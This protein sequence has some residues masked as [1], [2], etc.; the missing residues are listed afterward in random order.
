MQ[1]ALE[2]AHTV[3]MAV[4]NRTTDNPCVHSM[5]P[6]SF[7]YCVFAEVARRCDNNL[8]LEGIAGFS[9]WALPG[10]DYFKRADVVHLHVIHDHS[11]F[12]ILSLPNLS[13]LKPIVWTIHDPWAMTGGCLYS[14]ECDKWLD[15]CNFPC[16]YP[17]HKSLLQ[18][19]IPAILWQLK[20]RVYQRSDLSLVVASKWMQ[21]RVESSPL[22]Q[23]FPCHFIPF[24]IDIELFRPRSKAESRK[25]LG[26]C[27]DQKVIVFRDNGF[28][29]DQFKG[30][31]WLME[32]LQ[33]YEPQEPTCLL[34]LQDGRAFKPLCPKYSVIT[35]GWIDGEDLAI[36]LSA[37]DV[38]LMPSVQE[39][40]GLMAVESM[41]CG[42]P[43]ITFEGT[44]IPDV[45]KAPKGGL[46]VPAKD[47]SALALAIQ[48]LLRDDDLRDK[49]GKQARQIVE[50]EYS[51]QLYVQRHVSLYENVIESHKRGKQL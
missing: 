38:F 45:I 39:A 47:S 4:W 11:Y 2:S 16:P 33:M 17:R 43:V 44:S 26:I 19:R 15:G 14:F 49:L 3:E 20:M 6:G 46:A 9:G 24:G 51:F 34:I 29:S 12:S 42:T 37:A 1:E 25:L 21:G 50:Q 31:K 13:R 10:R 30:L 22:L 8:G 36:A 23:H 28:K 27:P 40:F 18:H 48:T 35:P 41:A 7:F 32:A 5:S